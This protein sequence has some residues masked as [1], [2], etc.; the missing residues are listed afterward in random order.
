MSSWNRVE[1][2]TFSAL[3]LLALGLRAYTLTSQPFWSDEWYTLK[4]V[5]QPTL[6]QDILMILVTD[7]YPPLFYG[8]TW[9]GVRLGG[10]GIFFLRLISFLG[11]VAAVAMVF[12]IARRW[13]GQ[14]AALYAGLLAALSPMGVYYAQEFKLY[15]FFAACGLWVLY[16]ALACLDEE[17][18]SWKRL[19][20]ATAV[21]MYTYYLMPYL[22]LPLFLA[23]AWVW[24]Q[25]WR[26]RARATATGLA[27]GMLCALPLLPFFLKA[28]MMFTAN[29]W[30]KG[31]H[32]LLW[33]TAQNF[34]TG[35]V[36][37]EALAQAAALFFAT[38]VAYNLRRRGKGAWAVAVM[39]AFAVLPSVVQWV[40]S[41]LARPS[42]SDRAMLG[43]AYAWALCAGLGASLLP[44]WLGRLALALAL[45]VNAYSLSLHYGP[46]T[47]S[48]YDY[49]ASYEALKRDWRPGD[50]VFH[51]QP[52]SLFPFCYFSRED[53]SGM[54]NWDK[55][56]DPGFNF[57][58]AVQGG[59]RYWRPVNAWL[60]ERGLGIDAGLD[61][62][63]VFAPRLDDLALKGVQRVWLVSPSVAVLNRCW[64]PLLNLSRN[65]FSEFQALDVEKETW[66][67]ERGFRLS[68]QSELSP[69]VAVYRFD[70]RAKSKGHGNA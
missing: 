65:G 12:I 22:L 49:Q 70:R 33:Y 57:N 28:A 13:A 32:L 23:A 9:V 18:R 37:P 25:G 26:Q 53:H 39:A 1:R 4:M 43:S 67:T 17:G 45:S 35:F 51:A 34:S 8:L 59:R 3:L 38:L 52:Q 20:L 44:P 62:A 69:G 41:E 11:G 46:E 6:F 40:Q 10:E 7:F 55:V 2:W 21:S 68:A 19:A 66:L 56:D 54:Q 5:S 47:R 58:A 27:L 15:S 16:E 29:F 60:K 48:R 36:A 31:K 61:S 30:D 50:A 64:I 24:A 63:Y 42:Y 14:R